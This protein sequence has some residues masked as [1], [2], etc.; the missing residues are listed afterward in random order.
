MIRGR[1]RNMN[2]SCQAG[3]SLTADLGCVAIVAGYC[4][5]RKTKPRMYIRGSDFLTG[6]GS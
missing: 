5:G 4:E 1:L 6:S 3:S 2:V